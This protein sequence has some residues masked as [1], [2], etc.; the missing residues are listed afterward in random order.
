MP[1][2]HSFTNE[3]DVEEEAI[4]LIASLGYTDLRSAEYNRP[5]IQVDSER[6]N[7]HQK[8]LLEPR[9]MAALK[10]INPGL[11]NFVY[12]E[13]MR[14]FKSVPDGPDLMAN[15]HHFHNLL[16]EGASVTE[17]KDGQPHTYSVKAIDFNNIA[18]NDF[19]VTDQFTMKQGDHNRRPDVTIFINGL[20]VVTFELKNQ[21][22][23]NVGIEEAYNQLQTYKQD[24]SDYMAY[25]EVLIASDGVNAR[26]GSLS[27][28]FD[29]FMQWRSPDHRDSDLPDSYELGTMITNMLKPTVILD[30][31]QNFIIF[32]SDDE[33]TSKILAAYHQYYMVNKAV[34]RAAETLKDPKN[35]RIGVVWHTQ[36][37]GKSLSMVFFSGIVSRKLGNPTV[38]VINDRNDL[39]DQLEQTFSAAHEY[40]RQTPKQAKSRTETRDLLAAN[41]GGIIFSTIQKFSPED[42][43]EAMPVLTN[44]SNVIVISDE[45]HRSQYGM[46]A[47]YTK[48]GV[49][50]GFA[51]YLR[52]SLPNA[53]FIGFTGTPINIDD[54]STTG[55]FGDYIDI[56]D[57]TQSVRDHTTVRIFYENHVIPLAADPEVQHKYEALIDEAGQI[58]P[59][60]TDD[61]KRKA[62][63]TSLERLAGATSRLKTLAKHFVHHFEA[64]QAVQ[65]GK[66][67]I[68]ETSRRNAVK[69]FN[70]IV[71]LRPMWYSD[72]LAKGKIKIVMTSDTASDGPELAKHHTNTK[73]RKTLQQRMKDDNDELQIVV[74]VNMW[75]TGFDAPSVNTMYID[76][77][78]HGHNLMQAIARVNR[79]FRDKDG[80]LIVDYIGIADSLNQALRHYS[81]NDRDQAGINVDKAVSLM[82]SKYDIIIN[83]YLYGVNYSG[84]NSAIRSKRQESYRLAIDAVVSLD[85]EQQK[86]FADTVVQLQKVYALVVT[87]EQAQAISSE[88]AFFGAV[89]SALIK[90]LQ[91]ANP[92]DNP[93]TNQE[94]NLRLDQLVNQSVIAKQPVDLYKEL[95]L[96]RPELSLLSEKFL[97]S[98]QNMPEQNLAVKLLERLLKGKVKAMTKVNLIQSRKFGDMLENNIEAL[99]QRGV[100]TEIVIRKLIELAKSM[101]E[102][103][104]AGESLGLSANE[105]AFYDALC[106]QKTA[107]QVMGEDTLQEIAKELVGTVR[108]YAATPDW[109][110]RKTTQAAMRQ[111]VRRMLKDHGYP[112]TFAKAAV[113][114]I[115]E[116]AQTMAFE[117][118]H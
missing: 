74:V 94:L 24:I 77:P 65:F 40:L 22:N 48:D 72:D 63:F 20:P 17:N 34:A 13:A 113:D 97:D 62:D 15:N 75:L 10:Q 89:K 21:A 38:L 105:Q 98:I 5:N 52:D 61:Q 3:Q 118:N 116:Q 11:P 88:V 85:K 46:K 19:M 90:V 2:S 92:R 93:V 16:I 51:Q 76:K 14:Q 106:D 23:E 110:Q 18:V 54:K 67:I 7:D 95:G 39:D 1:K 101:Q 104:A 41:S 60:V 31:I 103:E 53:S 26:T 107:V 9:L 108:K 28:G 84:Y 57:M 59:E 102:T 27:A 73:Q 66:A 87:S 114:N 58:G 35:N 91:A 56:Y 117:N 6:D 80:G 96:E 49:R 32:E 71:K 109:V 30:L 81:K 99:N 44:R 50:Y 12:L 36:G 4:D 78:M 82:K 70:E 115:I 25:N 100:T 37:S 8:V 42:G 69:L 45:A 64:H 111:A 29:R 86:K 112:P 83:D 47:R 43:E 68:V 33:K 55:V 79:V